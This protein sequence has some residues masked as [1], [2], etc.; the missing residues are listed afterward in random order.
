MARTKVLLTVNT[1]PLPSRSYDELV[2]TA[3]ILEDGSWI[4]IYPVPLSF[5]LG[6]RIS[7]KMETFK[8]NWIELDLIPR[9]QSNDFRPESYSPKYYDFRDLKILG[10]LDTKS[11]WYLRKQI[12][13]QNV[14][15]NFNQL[16]EDSKAP[17]N[18]SLATYRP[19]RIVGMD[20]EPDDREWKNEWTEIRKQGDLFNQDKNPEILV[21]KLP[22][23]FFYKFEDETGKIRRLMI[24]D[25]EIGALYWNSLR[26]TEGNEAEAL[27]KVR[28]RYEEEFLT[29]KEIYFFLGTTKQW[30]MRRAYNPFVIIGIFYPKLEI[31]TR[32]F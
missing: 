24:E 28:L 10:H 22:Y 8:Y 19:C 15:T 18:K 32:L 25:W 23:K 2:C 14:Y 1:Y 26:H 9:S 16:I 30:H 12:C 29:K 31:Q 11:N 6:Q 7:G 13:L 21:P 4:R 20:I 5:L 3:G 17:L 27:K